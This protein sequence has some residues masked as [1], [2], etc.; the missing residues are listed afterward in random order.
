M[1]INRETPWVAKKQ[2]VILTM[3]NGVTV[4]KGKVK[5]IEDG[6]VTFEEENDAGFITEVI[7]SPENVLLVKIVK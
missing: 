4:L 2:K 1:K 5:N 6:E 3:K 7:F